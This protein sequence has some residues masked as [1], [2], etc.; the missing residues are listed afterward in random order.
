[1]CLGRVGTQREGMSEQGVVTLLCRC[2]N[3]ATL[4]YIERALRFPEK[5]CL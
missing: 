4:T 1:M 3:N 5:S 2:R